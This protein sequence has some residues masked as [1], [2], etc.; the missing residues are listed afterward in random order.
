M[1]MK[2]LH[3]TL[4]HAAW[5]TIHLGLLTAAYID[6]VFRVQTPHLCFAFQKINSRRRRCASF[7]ETA[8]VLKVTCI[9]SH[10]HNCVLL[11]AE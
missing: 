10:G 7:K 4:A 9:H 5:N 11:E 1:K 3:A 8:V 6:I 2:N